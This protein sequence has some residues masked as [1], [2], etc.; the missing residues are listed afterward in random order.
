V[1]GGHDQ[2][3]GEGGLDGDLGGFQIAHFPQHDDVRV[4][5]E[6]GAQGAA[7]GHAHRF[8]DRYLHDAFHVVFHGVFDG[9]EFDVNA[10]DLVEAGVEGGGFAAAGGAGDDQDAVGL[11]DGLDQIITDG[12]G[13]AEGIDIQIDRRAIQ[14]AQHDRLAKLGGEGGNAQINFLAGR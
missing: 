6:E 4:L 14:D 7:E 2:V 1:E 8:I 5:A 9:E 3:A 12:L 13:Q 11:L 10:V